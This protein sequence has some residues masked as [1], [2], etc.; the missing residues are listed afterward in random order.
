LITL[1]RDAAMV[2]QARETFAAA[3]H[4]HK[5]VVMAGDA[6]RYLHKM[7]GPFDLVFQD[8]DARQYDSLHDRL[9]RL[10]APSATLITNRL[11]R[12]G[13]YNRVL[14]TDPRLATAMFNIAEGVAVSVRRGRLRSN[15]DA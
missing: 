11:T 5:V 15:D 12:A 6:A 10:L 4:A 14:A 2:A 13:D 8:G 7:A 9:V 3:G 1:E